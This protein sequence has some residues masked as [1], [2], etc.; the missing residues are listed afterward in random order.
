MSVCE[1]FVENFSPKM[2]VSPKVFQIDLIEYHDVS[3]NLESQKFE[4]QREFAFE[5]SASKSF[6]LLLA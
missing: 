2:S 4:S 6:G 3:E 1:N 5:A